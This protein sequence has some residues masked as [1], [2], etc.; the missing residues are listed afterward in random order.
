MQRA[1]LWNIRTSF[2]RYL[3]HSGPH[4]ITGERAS[5]DGPFVFVEGLGGHSGKSVFVGLIDIVAHGG[6]LRLTLRDPVLDIDSKGKG[7]LWFKVG[8]QALMTRL[9][10][11]SPANPTRWNAELTPDGSEVFDQVYPPGVPM[12]D[13]IVEDLALPRSGG[14]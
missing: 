12:A 14:S 11:L 9:L 5:D 8:E 7:S 2:L 4:R 3:D 1:L 13:V 10:D 6:L